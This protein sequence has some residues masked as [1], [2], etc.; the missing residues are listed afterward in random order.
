M[1]REQ[2]RAGL[3][4]ILIRGL[5]VTLIAAVA[6]AAL[7][8]SH[9]APPPPPSQSYVA[10]ASA[11]TRLSAP[12]LLI[13]AATS[14]GVECISGVAF[15]PTGTHVGVVGTTNPCDTPPGETSAHRLV[16]YDAVYGEAL[17]TVG[18]DDLLRA[19][20]ADAENR[21]IGSIRFAGLG[22]NSSGTRFAVAFAAIDRHTDVTLDDVVCSGLLVVDVD[23]GAQALIRGDAGLLDSGADGYSG[24]P[25]WNLKAAEPTSAF[26][27]EPG[28][29]YAWQRADSPQPIVALGH[30][31]IATLPV[32]AGPRYPVGDPV[33]G[34]T[35]TIWQP[36]VLFG[37]A[38]APQSAG[39]GHG[40][41]IT[42]FASWS[43]DGDQLAFMVAGVALAPPPR[44]HLPAIQPVAAPYVAVPP[45]LFLVPPRDPALVEVQREIGPGGWAV[46]AWN[47]SGS[48]LAS[49]NCAD[50]APKLELRDT[51]TGAM[52]D[53]VPLS[54]G[55]SGPICGSSRQ[56]EPLGAYATPNPSLV[57][58]PDGA[59]LLLAD[60]ASAIV[61]V[62]TVTG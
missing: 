28:L 9:S 41:F 17:A 4:A 5:V 27:P 35:F 1:G 29:V 15:S 55:G 48:L 62:W 2:G 47:P 20:L 12:G 7:A 37:P 42:H 30:D 39:S 3:A 57:W 13:A 19:Q 6:L 22:W 58:S 10:A 49:I 38:S 45:S 51:G 53:G 24:L 50:S 25:G 14:A 16:V 8:A 34:A 26:I 60:Q 31:P 40:A 21:L 44:A 46:V 36:G 52:V 59:R 32:I 11:T 43:P 54:A 18:L 23:G 61:R 56:G 33:G